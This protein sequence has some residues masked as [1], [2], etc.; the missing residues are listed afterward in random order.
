MKLLLLGLG[1]AMILEGIP[2]FLSPGKVKELA[3]L[4]PGLPDS[5]LRLLGLASMFLGLLLLYITRRLLP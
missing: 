2:Y 4:L 3:R 5:A 1:L